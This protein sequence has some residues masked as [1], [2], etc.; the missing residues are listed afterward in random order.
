MGHLQEVMKEKKLGQY[1]QAGSPVGVADGEELQI[2]GPAYYM[3]PEKDQGNKEIQSKE[4]EYLG[5]SES[6]SG[7]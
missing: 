5:L 1:V 2:L 6:P 4:Q 7:V 3:S